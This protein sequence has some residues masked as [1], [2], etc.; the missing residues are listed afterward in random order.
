LHLSVPVAVADVQA[1]SALWRD[2][3]YCGYPADK[4]MLV[5]DASATRDSIFRALD[6]LTARTTER[7]TVLLFYSS[8]GDY[9]DD[10]SYCLIIH[11]TRIVDHK[12]VSSSGLS[13]QEL[14]EKLHNL[15]AR[16]VLLIFDTG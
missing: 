7:D 6:S 16:R 10:A 14:L 13:Q 12:L 9:A 11:D 4:V 15:K 5:H 1:L 8:Q 3:Q 2:P